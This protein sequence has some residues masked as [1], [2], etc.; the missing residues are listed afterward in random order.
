MIEWLVER[1][2]HEEGYRQFPY[3]CTA[4]KLTIGIGRNLED[5]GLTINEAKY[6][7]VND[8]NNAICDLLAHVDK[9]E[10]LNNARQVV[11]IDM[12]FNMGIAGLLKFRKMIEAIEAGDCDTAAHE[13]LNSLWAK[14]VGKRANKLAEIMITGVY[15][16]Y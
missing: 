1:L 6:L 14:Q 12:V 9:Y 5:R 10:E 8:I 11:L 2:I 4:D 7:C 13:M 3:R 15:V 16:E